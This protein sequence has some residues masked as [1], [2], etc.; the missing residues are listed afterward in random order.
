[1]KYIKKVISKYHNKN[2]KPKS[3]IELLRI[4]DRT[5]DCWYW[6]DRCISDEWYLC[7]KGPV[8]LAMVHGGGLP[9]E[10]YWGPG[11]H[12]WA[13]TSI[14]MFALFDTQLPFISAFLLAPT[15]ALY[16]MMRH[17]LT[18]EIFTWS[19]SQYH[20]IFTVALT[21]QSPQHHKYNSSKTWYFLNWR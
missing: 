1:M 14:Y 8:G 3:H 21:H 15:A 18:F 19:T 20:I 5:F 7:R 13:P 11:A 4:T 12:H 2:T 17:Y 9:L 6:K 16:V 10:R